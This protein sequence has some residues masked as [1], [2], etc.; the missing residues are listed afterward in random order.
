MSH[1]GVNMELLYRVL[2]SS[3]LCAV[4]RVLV[5]LVESIFF[6][7]SGLPNVSSRG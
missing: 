3:T 7:H 1:D 6:R 2:S 5:S 4:R